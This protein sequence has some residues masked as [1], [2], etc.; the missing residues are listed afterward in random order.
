MMAPRVPASLA[1]KSLGQRG[2]FR[3]ELPFEVITPVFGGGIHVSADKL[4]RHNK[5][6]DEVT[7]I[8]SAAIRGQL[9]F[10]WR[11]LVGGQG[12][13]DSIESL[14]TREIALWGGPSVPGGVSIALSGKDVDVTTVEIFALARTRNDKPTVKALA[15]RTGIPY[16]AFPL[17]PEREAVTRDIPPGALSQLTGTTKLTIF[18][19]QSAEV[20]V[21]HAVQAWLNYG[22]LGGRTRRGF[23]AVWSPTALGPDD[24]FSSLR[25]ASPPLRLVPSLQGARIETTAPT[26]GNGLD[27]L[28][29]GLAQLRNLRQGIDIGRNPP[30]SDKPAGR[31]RWPEAECIRVDTKNPFNSHSQRLVNV[32]K[33]PRAAFGMP[34]LFPFQGADE[35]KG[36]R[37]MPRNYERMASP[38]ILRPFK[39]GDGQ[40]GSLA[41]ALT[42]N[43]QQS[44]QTVLKHEDGRQI[45]VEARLE[46]SEAT[47]VSPLQGNVDPVARFL[48]FFYSQARS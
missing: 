20:E 47:R 32:N 12:N 8:R 16:G 27:A 39:Q 25:L 11:A 4:K 17:Q 41:L 14:R 2:L 21:A 36:W 26:F 43:G 46:P 18:G 3:L 29:W 30:S 19:P 7:P 45:A 28:E 5:K 48:D 35:P 44:E 1:S 22:G 24:Y 9:R 15:N 33:Y 10:W 40:F 23:G 6:I 34:I 42:V 37:L 13:F 31:S 38:L